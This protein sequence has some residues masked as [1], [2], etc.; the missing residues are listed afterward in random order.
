MKDLARRFRH[1]LTQRVFLR[2]YE[3]RRAGAIL[4]RLREVELTQWLTSR[5]LD[6]YRDR[7]FR[8]LIRH[9]YEHVPYYR[10][11]MDERGLRPADFDT[12]ADVRKLPILTKATVREHRE[13]LIAENADPRTLIWITTGGS[14]GQPLPVARDPACLA[15]ARAEQWR[16]FGWSGWRLGD[17]LVTYQHS[18]TPPVLGRI[19]AR[20]MRRYLEPGFADDSSFVD[21]LHLLDRLSAPWVEGYASALYR[22]AELAAEHGTEFGCAG[23]FSTAE[24]LYPHQRELIERTFGCSV[25][26]YYGST[27]VHC[28]AFPCSHMTRHVCADHLIFET[29]DETGRSIEA[30]PG[31]VVLTDFDNLAMPLIRYEN[32]DTATLSRERCACGRSLPALGSLDGRSQE[33]LRRRDGSRVPALYF[34]VEFAKRE[35]I[36]RYQVI[37]TDFERVE[38]KVVPGNGF[39]RTEV[40]AMVDV[41]RAK[42]GAATTVDVTTVDGIPRTERGKM[43]AVICKVPQVG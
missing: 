42:L 26:D 30:Q 8:G 20:L 15:W 41:I 28:L 37:Q 1:E 38:L 33:Y 19:R 34:P 11:C 35:G 4:A 39:R 36:A 40:D 16:G 17:P 3:P 14:T 6:D 2:L 22:V 12:T 24:M 27:E 10:R 29:I 25:S 18:G 7:R 5:E 9:A 43:R 21:R 23:A 13:E 32:G 31:N